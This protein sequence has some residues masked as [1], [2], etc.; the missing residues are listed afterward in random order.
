MSTLSTDATDATNGTSN[1]ASSL[2]GLLGGQLGNYQS[3]GLN[4]TLQNF[5]ITG[6]SIGNGSLSSLWQNQQLQ[7]VAGSLAGNAITSFTGN[8]NGVAT[9]GLGAAAGNALQTLS[10]NGFKLSSLGSTSSVLGMGNAA[11][12][13]AFGNTKKAGWEKGVSSA[14]GAL[15]NVPVIGTYAAAANLAFN[16]IGGIG[17]SKT[18]GATS[19]DWQSREDQASVAGGYSGAINDIAEAEAMEGTYSLWNGGGK[20]NANNQINKTNSWKKTMSEWAQRNDLNDI[21]SNQMASI[22]GLQYANDVSGGYNLRNSGQLFVA[23]NGGSLSDAYAEIKQFSKRIREAKQPQRFIIEEDF[24]LEYLEKEDNNQELQAYKEGG[25]LDEKEHNIIPDGALHARLNHMDNDS[26]TKKGIPVVAK[27]GDKIEQVAEIER[28][29]IIFTL[30]VTNK[31]EELMKD[32]SPKAAL[33]A[34]KLLTEEILRNT[35]DNTGLLKE[36]E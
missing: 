15:S 20:K 3:L 27:D 21:R 19:K 13:A 18:V 22:N 32:G 33:E 30:S 7:N 34:G 9:R 25:K 12:N 1:G 26:Y 29:E 14:L 4:S 8:S 31:L 16:A 5:P 24:P 23:K 10:S 35:T 6:V 2:Q 11:V 36:V 17:A 28:N